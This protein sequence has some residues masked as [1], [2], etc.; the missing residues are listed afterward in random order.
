MILVTAM[1]AEIYATQA[2]WRSFSEKGVGI[3]TDHDLSMVFMWAGMRTA[4]TGDF[5]FQAGYSSGFPITEEDGFRG[6][7][8]LRGFK[9]WN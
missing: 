1:K 8:E 5:C 3:S 4:K 2:E 7:R 9:F 6:K